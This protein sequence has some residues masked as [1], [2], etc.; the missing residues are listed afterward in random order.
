MVI[1]FDLSFEFLIFKFF[2]LIDVGSEFLIELSVFFKKGWGRLVF[3]FIE[4]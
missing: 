1:E 3:D 2:Y 4:V